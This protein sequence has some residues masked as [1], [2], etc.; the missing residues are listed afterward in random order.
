MGSPKPGA[1]G[2]RVERGAGADVGTELEPAVVANQ[3]LE[4][5]AR[6]TAEGHEVRLWS[7]VLVSTRAHPGL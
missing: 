3:F 2:A 7:R 6:A 4:A 5:E 1:V